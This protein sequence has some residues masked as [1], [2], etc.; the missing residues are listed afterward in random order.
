MFCFVLPFK[1]S[2][3]I[4]KYFLLNAGVSVMP[5]RIRGLFFS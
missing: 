3:F 4:C 5:V 2:G 1:G